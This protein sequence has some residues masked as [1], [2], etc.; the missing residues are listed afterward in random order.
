MASLIQN[1]KS[2]NQQLHFP[3]TTSTANSIHH[4]EKGVGNT[5][6]LARPFWLTYAQMEAEFNT[7][8]S[9]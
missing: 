9:M 8:M 4:E 1:P 5:K 7:N 3:P 6:P 2:F